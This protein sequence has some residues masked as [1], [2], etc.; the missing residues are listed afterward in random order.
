MRIVLLDDVV[1]QTDRLCI[2]V[3]IYMEW[4]PSAV[5]PVCGVVVVHGLRLGEVYH[6]EMAGSASGVGIVGML[7]HHAEFMAVVMVC[8]G[9]DR[10]FGAQ[11]EHAEHGYAAVLQLS[12]DLV[13]TLEITL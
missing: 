9:E 5:V 12:D 4:L 10:G 6:A 11:Q 2:H 7:E 3:G 8:S 1:A 13:L